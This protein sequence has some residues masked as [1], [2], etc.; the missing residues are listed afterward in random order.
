MCST[1]RS[2]ED[3]QRHLE[4]VLHERDYLFDE[5]D[6]DRERYIVALKKKNVKIKELMEKVNR[7]HGRLYAAQKRVE[8]KW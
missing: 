2:A 1:E 8:E 4:S 3:L 6:R 7:L 5:K